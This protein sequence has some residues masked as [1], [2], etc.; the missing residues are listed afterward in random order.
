MPPQPDRPAPAPEPEP[1]RFVHVDPGPD[2]PETGGRTIAC[3]CHPG[4]RG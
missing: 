3:T 4:R 2:H 1:D